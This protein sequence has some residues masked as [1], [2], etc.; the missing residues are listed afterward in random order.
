MM[1]TQHD[2]SSG[3]YI[4]LRIFLE[5]NMYWHNTLFSVEAHIVQVQFLKFL[6]D[7]QLIIPLSILLLGICYGNL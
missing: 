1:M 2:E 3:S 6:V 7:D 4:P 5:Q